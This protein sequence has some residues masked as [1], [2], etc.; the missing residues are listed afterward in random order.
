MLTPSPSEPVKEMDPLLVERSST[1]F[2][3][4]DIHVAKSGMGFHLALRIL[5][6]HLAGVG[7]Q[8]VASRGGFFNLHIAEIAVR[9]QAILNLQTL[10]V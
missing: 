2:V 7:V 3:P 10:R 4:L 5:R 6:R 8:I 9:D 1:T